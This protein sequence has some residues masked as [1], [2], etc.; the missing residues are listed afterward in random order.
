MVHCEILTTYTMPINATKEYIAIRN[1]R[2]HH[3]VGSIPCMRKWRRDG[4]GSVAVGNNDNLV[5]GDF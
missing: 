5:V 2:Y 3:E 4:L 1:V